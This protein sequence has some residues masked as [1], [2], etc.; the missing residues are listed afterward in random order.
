MA[1]YSISLEVEA[2]DDYNLARIVAATSLALADDAG[3][4]AA[5]LTL[6]WISASKD[7]E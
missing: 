1:K 5:D 4:P 2:P 6:V 7:E 3:S